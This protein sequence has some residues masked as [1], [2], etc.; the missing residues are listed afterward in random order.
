MGKEAPKIHNRN[1]NRG[2]TNTQKVLL[3]S[4][5]VG[6]EIGVLVPDLLSKLT[7]V[8]FG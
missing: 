2:S 4:Y 1:D 5:T 3:V 8:S 7:A 6:I